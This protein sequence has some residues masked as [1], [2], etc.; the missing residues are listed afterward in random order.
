MGGA[1]QLDGQQVQQGGV[2]SWIPVI[3]ASCVLL[4]RWLLF[5]QGGTP[6]KLR[7]WFNIQVRTYY[8]SLCLHITTVHTWLRYI[9][10]D[11]IAYTYIYLTIPVH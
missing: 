5:G 4:L 7:R 2:G 6:I 8:N 3:V 11:R 9:R 10:M 1:P